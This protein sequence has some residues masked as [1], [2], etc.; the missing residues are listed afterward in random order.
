[1]RPATQVHYVTAITGALFYCSNNEKSNQYAYC[2]S[3]SVVHVITYCIRN[4][5]SPRSP[6]DLIIT[7]MWADARPQRDGYPAAYR[8]RPLRK[9]RNSIPCTR[10]KVWL[11]LA[12]GVPCSNAANVGERKTWTQSE[13]CTG[14]NSVTGQEPQKMY[15]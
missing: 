6:V 1:M 13:F 3:L 11:M 14:Q 8:W 9:F 15:I 12:A 5:Y 2:V 7:R 4:T 10:R